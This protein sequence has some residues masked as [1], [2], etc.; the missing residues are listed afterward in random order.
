[1]LRTLNTQ[2]LGFAFPCPAGIPDALSIP[3]FRSYQGQKIRKKS[4]AYLKAKIGIEDMRL[5]I[6]SSLCGQ[7]VLICWC[8]GLIKWNDK[9]NWTWNRNEET[10]HRSEISPSGQQIRSIQMSTLGWAEGLCRSTPHALPATVTA[11]PHSEGITILAWD[12]RPLEPLSLTIRWE[13]RCTFHGV[14]THHTYQA[15]LTFVRACFFCLLTLITKCETQLWHKIGQVMYTEFSDFESLHN[16]QLFN[17]TLSPN[18]MNTFSPARWSPT[19]D[20]SAVTLAT[21][22]PRPP[23]SVVTISMFFSS[24]K[25][26][27]YKY[28]NDASVLNVGSPA[29]GYDSNLW[30]DQKVLNGTKDIFVRFSLIYHLVFNFLQKR[31]KLFQSTNWNARH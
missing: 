26:P 22:W 24:C 17:K 23:C 2:H 20:S 21:F 19:L 4:Q 9:L 29:D 1:M 11:D 5:S 3:R 27:S 15:K 7:C 28:N 30:Q 14:F 10:N 16:Q 12:P 13:F 6:S 25:I 8:D 31:T 18:A